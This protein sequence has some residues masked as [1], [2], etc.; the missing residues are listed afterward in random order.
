MD[1][2]KGEPEGKTGEVKSKLQ[3][4]PN[5]YVTHHIG[6]STEQ[7]QKAVAEETVRIIKSYLHSGVIAHWVNK[8]K[9]LMLNI[10]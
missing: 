7:A 6:A 4:S 9:K 5:V 8:A 3:S 10:S 2:F 1:V